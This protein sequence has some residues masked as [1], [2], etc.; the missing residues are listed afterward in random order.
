MKTFGVNDSNEETI[1]KLFTHNSN[2]QPGQV[3]S[4]YPR[5]IFCKKLYRPDFIPTSMGLW[6]FLTMQIFGRRC[7][8]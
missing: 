4:I 2:E 7:I 5:G 3:N 1:F 8:F 6:I